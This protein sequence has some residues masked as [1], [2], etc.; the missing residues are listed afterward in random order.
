MVFGNKGREPESERRASKSKEFIDNGF[1]ILGVC[2]DKIKYG[3][4]K[5][6]PFLDDPDEEALYD[7]GTGKEHVSGEVIVTR[8]VNT[9][10]IVYGLLGGYF[11]QQYTEYLFRKF[12]AW[13]VGVSLAT[14]NIPAT[15]ITII[16]DIL[17]VFMIYTAGIVIMTLFYFIFK[18]TVSKRVYEG[19]QMCQVGFMYGI[20]CIVFMTLLW[21]VLPFNIFLP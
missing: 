18:W 19:L 3:L 8:F 17:I 4:Q 21:I 7:D 9:V 10:F 6:L 11:M 5:V 13:T 12:A 2:F 20:L 16:V 15:P 14:E 1:H